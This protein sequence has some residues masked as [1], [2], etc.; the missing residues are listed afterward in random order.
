MVLDRRPSADPS[1]GV[2]EG[3]QAAGSAL[4]FQPENGGVKYRLFLPRELDPAGR[5]CLPVNSDVASAHPHRPVVFA[6]AAED[7]DD[8]QALEGY[9]LPGPPWLPAGRNRFWRTPFD[10]DSPVV[11]IP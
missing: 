5:R 9:Y 3:R 11:D 4:N 7:D 1:L 2:V 10:I 8:I 6:V